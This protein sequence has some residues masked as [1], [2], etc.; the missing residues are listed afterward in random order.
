MKLKLILF[1]SICLLSSLLISATHAVKQDGTGDYLTIQAGINASTNNDTVLVYPG[2]YYENLQIINKNIVLGSLFLTT[3][4][5]NYI[6]QTIIDGNESGSCIEIRNCPSGNAKIIGLNLCNGSGTQF[7]EYNL[8]IVGGGVFAEN[9]QLTIDNCLIHNN[10]A[11][12][13]GGIVLYESHINLS[14]STIRYNKSYYSGGGLAIYDNSTITFDEENLCNIY[15]NYSGGGNEIIKSF[16]NPPL[17]VIV[18]TFTVANPDINFITSITQYGMP[19]NDITFE[20]NNTKLTPVDADLYVSVDG[21]NNNSG[22]SAEEPLATINYALSLIQPNENSSNTIHLADGIYSTSLNDQWFP[23][24]MRSYTNLSGQ[25]MENTVLDGEDLSPIM[26]DKNSELNYTVSNLNIINGYGLSDMGSGIPWVLCFNDS[27]SR[28]KWVNLENIFI[29]DCEVKARLLAIWFIKTHI[30]N[31]HFYQCN[32]NAS[33]IDIL[34]LPDQS[35]PFYEVDIVNS[36]IK[37]SI[38]SGINFGYISN[39]TDYSPVKLTNLE[40]SY[41]HNQDYQWPSTVCG[42]WFDSFRDVK[43]VNCTIAN[44]AISTGNGG[45]LYFYGWGTNL[46]IYNSIIHGNFPRNIW[47]ENETEAYPNIINIYNSLIPDSET[48][49]HSVYDWDQI[50]FRSGNISDGTDPQW[51]GAEAEWPFGLTALSPCIDAGTLD[52][53]GGIELPEYDLAGNP[54]IY[55]D[56]IDMGAY[57]FQGP[58]Q[59]IE[60]EEIIIPRAN[61]ITRYPN[62][63]YPST[64]GHRTI[65]NIKLDLAESGQIEFAIYNIKGQKVKGLLDAYSKQGHFELQWNGVDNNGKPV[66]SG[67]YLIKLSVN[68]ELRKAEKITVI[69]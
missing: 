30:N 3:E 56:S 26:T 25:S 11:E 44:N 16:N 2:T 27:Q 32:G 54:R 42:I 66:A 17:E 6:N 58:Q 40:I 22:L 8:G 15:L 46:D 43:M 7:S 31:V 39:E 23:L 51:A 38:T 53:P 21:D 20:C 69:K 37:S 35:N 50:N 19:I 67:N 63:F 33:T 29:E 5:C 36:S 57:E 59:D 24:Q 60:E 14:E 55:G 47:I 4:D 34:R 28:H 12:S 9:S 49:N 48:T 10:Y 13:G 41:N 68:G 65:T 18:D 64:A 45:S 1:C 52:L 62:P 61:K